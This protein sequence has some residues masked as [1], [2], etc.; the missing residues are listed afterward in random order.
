MPPPSFFLLEY[1]VHVL[2]SRCAR[3]NAYVTQSLG[4]KWP[5]RLW[6]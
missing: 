2:T 1:M 3:Y 5:L 4:R 6:S